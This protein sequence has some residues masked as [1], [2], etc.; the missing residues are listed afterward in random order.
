MRSL[1]ALALSALRR[2]IVFLKSEY[3]NEI[4]DLDRVRWVFMSA[5]HSTIKQTP[6]QRLKTIHTYMYFHRK[7]KILC[8]IP[9]AH[10][11]TTFK[12]VECILLRHIKMIVSRWEE[13]MQN[14]HKMLPYAPE[15]TFTLKL[16]PH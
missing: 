16:H 14:M 5:Y 6:S 9:Y 1:K 15:D 13:L 12:N 10:D 7:C 8:G 11:D 4:D 2:K 3:Q